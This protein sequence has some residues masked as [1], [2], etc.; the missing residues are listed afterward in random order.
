MSQAPSAPAPVPTF[1]VTAGSPT[2]EEIAVVVA[3]LMS[4]SNV[5]PGPQVRRLRA[6]TSSPWRNRP[7]LTPVPGGWRLSGMRM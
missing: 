6:W 5:D 7:Q 1:T 2:P 4:L 3:V